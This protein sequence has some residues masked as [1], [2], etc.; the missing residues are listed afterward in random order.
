ME[1]ENFGGV[2]PQ[3]AGIQFRCLLCGEIKTCKAQGGIVAMEGVVVGAGVLLSIADQPELSLRIGAPEVVEA[4]IE[5]GLLRGA[6]A[7]ELDDVAGVAGAVAELLKGGDQ[8]RG[9]DFAIR[10]AV[11]ERLGVGDE[12][13]LPRDDVLAVRQ[14]V[15]ARVG[16]EGDVCVNTQN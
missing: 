1:Q 15:P 4:L 5:D 14:V 2:R 9:L 3:K 13:G 16:I 6:S 7:C 10:Q 8:R 11:Q 12:L